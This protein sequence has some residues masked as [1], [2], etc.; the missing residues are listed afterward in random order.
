[1]TLRHASRAVLLLPLAAPR[2]D[3]VRFEIKVRVWGNTKRR[4]KRE[5]GYLLFFSMEKEG[6]C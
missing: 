4:Y 3:A 5:D 1:M 6:H 2:L